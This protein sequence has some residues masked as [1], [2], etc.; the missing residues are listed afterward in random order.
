MSYHMFKCRQFFFV[1]VSSL[2]SPLIHS[3]SLPPQIE[4]KVR[5]LLSKGPGAGAGR[6]VAMT[7]LEEKLKFVTRFGTKW[8]AFI[9]K[10]KCAFSCLVF[11]CLPLSCHVLSCLVMTVFDSII[12]IFYYLNSV[13]VF[14]LHTISPMIFT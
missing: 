11:F 8:Q 5:V 7:Q 2:L 3:L 12:Y 6:T 13:K 9:G 4:S 10:S 14:K 1:H